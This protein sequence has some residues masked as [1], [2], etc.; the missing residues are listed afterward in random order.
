MYLFIY[1]MACSL[2]YLHHVYGV[3]LDVKDCKRFSTNHRGSVF[4]EAEAERL[5]GDDTQQGAGV[6]NIICYLPEPLHQ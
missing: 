4:V 6:S 1:F 2:A 3:Q 5:K